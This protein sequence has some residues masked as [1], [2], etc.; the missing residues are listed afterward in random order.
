MLGSITLKRSP[1]GL[2]A[3]PTF[4]AF[5]S[6]PDDDLDVAV[7][8]AL[9]ARDHHAELDAASLVRELEALGSALAAED[10]AGW[11]VRAQID[12]L[13]RFVYGELGFAG[14][15]ADYYDP[16]NS[17][18]PDVMARRRGIPITLA[19]VYG[20]IARANGVDVAGVGFPGHFLLRVGPPDH[21]LFVDPFDKGRELDDASLRALLRRAMGHDAHLD[22]QLLEP[23]KGRQ[24]LVRM[25]TNLKN[26]FAGRGDHARAFLALDRIANL[27][28]TSTRILREHAMAASVIGA[29]EIAR[30]DIERLLELE[31]L[32]PDVETLRR[33]LEAL[34]PRPA[35]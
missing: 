12:R 4:E 2:E 29:V 35:N 15:A 24:I 7:G 1:R 3:L 30:A 17:L 27:V 8:A 22:P 19:L 23:T 25:L 10:I 26:A 14:D 32:A 13:S 20:E 16:K 28:P 18:L 31:P 9:Y 6:E 5:A 34:V 11:P 33:R 21:A